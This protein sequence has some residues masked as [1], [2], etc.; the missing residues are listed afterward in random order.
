MSLESDIVTR[1]AAYSTLNTLIAG[2]IY[3]EDAAQEPTLPCVVFQVV[4]G[5]RVENRTMGKRAQIA[6]ARIQMDAYAESKTDLVTLRDAVIGAFDAVTF[7]IVLNCSLV[8]ER[9]LTELLDTSGQVRRYSMNF[10]MQ[11]SNPLYS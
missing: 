2:R 9:S 11:Y 6:S 10:M 3:S 4:D 8:N 5:E 7:G 1:A